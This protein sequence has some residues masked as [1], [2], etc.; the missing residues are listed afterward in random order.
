MTKQRDSRRTFRFTAHYW[1]AVLVAVGAVLTGGCQ[2]MATAPS[3]DL[4]EVIAEIGFAS[5]RDDGAQTVD[6]FRERLKLDAQVSG[7]LIPEETVTLLI[8]GVANEKLTGG[9]VQLLLPTF[10]AM[11]HVGN[12]KRPSYP[13][14][15]D[16]PVAGQWNVPAMDKGGLWKASV[17]IELPGK[18]YYHVAV[19]AE[20]NAP[21]DKWDPYVF[22]DAYGEL[23]LVV[24]DGGGYTTP[25]FDEEVF[26]DDLV[27]QPGPF[28][29][30]RSATATDQLGADMV[31][32]ASSDDIT[33]EPIYYNRG[34]WH[35]TVSAEV[36]ARY[37]SQSDEHG[38]V[39]TKT[40]PSRGTV[41]FACPDDYEYIVVSVSIPT[42]AEVEADYVIGG[43]DEFDD[44]DCGNTE[45]VYALNYYYLPWK[46][47]KEVIPKIE[48]HFDK[49]RSRANWTVELKRK[50][51]GYKDH[52]DKIY[53]R[54]PGYQSRWTAA[55]EFGH[56]LHHEALGG[57]W[58]TTNCDDHEIHLPSSYTCAMSEGFADYATAIGVGTAAAYESPTY[59]SS[60]PPGK[61]EGNI[62]KLF[63]DLID[64]NNEGDDET[65]YSAE[66]V[67]DVMR[68]CR[69]S[70]SSSIN[71][72]S[73]FVWCLENRVNTSVH[74][75]N[76][77]GISAPSSASE[78]ATKPSDWDA[79]DI[80]DTW[81]QNVG[82]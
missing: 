56:A 18:G 19:E 81:L 34:N 43:G 10:A 44:N 4:A 73:D 39:V 76:F 22:D 78:S 40:V 31:V 77:P 7:E 80:R 51:S 16:F 45:Q 14:G 20:I 47:L 30:K 62:A 24:Q 55:H 42:T 27:P 52:K 50:P 21:G 82:K 67:V 2:D 12:D 66:Y 63:T 46:H 48:D 15:K 41:S 35:S 57:I 38:Y 33:I 72:V 74:N 64:P 53:F 60:E 59:P 69:V 71:D 11:D 1:K 36:S 26:G 65:N 25:H 61:I 54:I 9:E 79:D 37:K 3:P 13:V 17:D 70:G 58:D 5:V 28:R 8:E 29:T 6:N 75:Y 23:W 32:A 68:T 49:D